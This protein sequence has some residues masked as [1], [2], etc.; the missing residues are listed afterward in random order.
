M[1]FFYSNS[2]FL[3]CVLFFLRQNMCFHIKLVMEQKVTSTEIYTYIFFTKGDLKFI[4]VV[5]RLDKIK[6]ALYVAR[7]KSTF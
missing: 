7:L 6:I 1:E 3:T 2:D 4:L 5:S